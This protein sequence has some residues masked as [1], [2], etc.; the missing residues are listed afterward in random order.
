MDWSDVT[1]SEQVIEMYISMGYNIEE[2]KKIAEE[3]FE[4]VGE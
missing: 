4:E 2:A 3:I 1:N